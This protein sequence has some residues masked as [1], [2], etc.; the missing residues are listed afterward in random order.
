MVI[1]IINRKHQEMFSFMINE[2]SVYW[3]YTYISFVLEK[4]IEMKWTEGV[5]IMLESQVLMT[6]FNSRSILGRI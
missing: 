6:L 1:E 5:L 2:C 3:N 4:C